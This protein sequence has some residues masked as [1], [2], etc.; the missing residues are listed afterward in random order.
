MTIPYLERLSKPTIG[1]L[2]YQNNGNS[3]DMPN[4]TKFAHDWAQEAMGDKNFRIFGSDYTAAGFPS[5]ENWYKMTILPKGPTP[6]PGS[7]GCCSSEGGSMHVFA[8]LDVYDNGKC[9]I[10]DSRYDADK[11]LRNERFFRVL[12]DVTLTVGKANCIPGCG[13]IQG[14][15]YLPVNDLRTDRNPQVDQVEIYSTLV[16]C[17]DNYG[18]NTN[19][20]NPGCYVLPGFYN[21]LETQNADGYVWCKIQNGAWFAAKTEG[22]GAWANLYL[23]NPSPTP[24]PTPPTPTP[25][26]SADITKLFA[27]ITKQFNTLEDKVKALESENTE[28]KKGFA[29][30]AEIAKRYM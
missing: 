29:E 12:D 28:L 1:S 21:V 14:F 3:N 7:I 25:D 18:L 2:Y 24:T 10:C 19:V 13:K 26:P 5:A 17:R 8:V 15:I 27:E 11:S 4:C 9:V 6:Q 22:S 30:I 20:I 16:H 23:I